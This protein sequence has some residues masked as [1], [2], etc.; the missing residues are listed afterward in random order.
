MTPLS[1]VPAKA[2]DPPTVP[3]TAAV[4][5]RPVPIAT[6]KARFARLPGW[7]ANCLPFYLFC[8]LEKQLLILRMPA[9]PQ[10]NRGPPCR[11]PSFMAIRL[12][13]T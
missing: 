12:A 6:R 3:V 5:A 9:R 11:G 1:G 2:K 8:L 4:V 10:A 13:Y 7:V